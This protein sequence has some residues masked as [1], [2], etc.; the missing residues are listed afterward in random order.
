MTYANSRQQKKGPSA[1]TTFTSETDRVDDGWRRFEGV[2]FLS[3]PSCTLACNLGN[4]RSCPWWLGCSVC[5]VFAFVNDGIDDLLIAVFAL[6]LKHKLLFFCLQLFSFSVDLLT[7]RQKSLWP[8]W[9]NESWRKHLPVTRF[10]AYTALPGPS[11]SWAAIAVSLSTV[12]LTVNA[13]KTWRLS[14]RRL[15]FLLNCLLSTPRPLLRGLG[16]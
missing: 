6:I 7:T 11:L 9:G 2:C 5:Y 16:Q 1:F 8:L 3:L 12:S 4:L 13:V 15:N 14:D 10:F